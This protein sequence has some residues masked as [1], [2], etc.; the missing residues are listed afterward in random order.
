MSRLDASLAETASSKTQSTPPTAADILQSILD[1]LR[2]T[3]VF[4][5]RD[6]TTSVK[7]F[8]IALKELGYKELRVKNFWGP[9]DGYQGI[10]TVFVSPVRFSICLQS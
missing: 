8:I 2:Y 4:Q 9:G 6:Y 5:T 7:K 1:V 3:A 10:N